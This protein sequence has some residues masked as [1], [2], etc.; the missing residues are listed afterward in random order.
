MQEA[1]NHDLDLNLA[2]LSPEKKQIKIKIE[3]KIK[4]K[5]V[6]KLTPLDL[7]LISIRCIK[8]L[9]KN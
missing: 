1:L 6:L 8:K 5:F 4:R 3:I 7:A 9:F 2:F